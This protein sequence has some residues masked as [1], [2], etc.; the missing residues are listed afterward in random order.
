MYLLLYILFLTTAFVRKSFANGL[1]ANDNS[2][3]WI[4]S[5]GYSTNDDGSDISV[6]DRILSLAKQSQINIDPFKV[7]YI[8]STFSSDYLTHYERWVHTNNDWMTS[9]LLINAEDDFP[10]SW[11]SSRS[12]PSELKFSYELLQ[13]VSVGFELLL[14]DAKS[15]DSSENKFL[16]YFVTCKNDLQQLLCEISDAIEI[17][18]QERPVDVDRDAIPNEIRQESSMAQRNLTN[19]IIFRDYMIA[20]KYLTSTYSYFYNKINDVIINP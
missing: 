12:F 7:N 16:S 14:E 18:E 13:Q 15:N 3:F 19:S 5:C 6:I 20:I 2:P 8:I 9:R 17:T 1:P 10:Q 11:L 4:N